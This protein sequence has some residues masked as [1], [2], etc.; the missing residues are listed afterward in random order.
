MADW[1]TLCCAR[2][3][4]RNTKTAKKTYLWNLNATDLNLES[5]PMLKIWYESV[6]T[7]RQEQRLANKRH[8]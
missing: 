2:R 6:R 1:K 8:G 4:R 3:A 7:V 5:G